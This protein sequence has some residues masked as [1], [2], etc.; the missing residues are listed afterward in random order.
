M[1]RMTIIAH[2]EAACKLFEC[3]V[4]Y[5]KLV[6]KAELPEVPELDS[7]VVIGVLP[8]PESPVVKV[9]APNIL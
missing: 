3:L 6:G 7:D 1:E 8:N 9:S 2:D 4:A 5:H